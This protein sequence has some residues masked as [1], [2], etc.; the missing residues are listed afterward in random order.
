MV[1]GSDWLLPSRESVLQKELQLLHHRC[2]QSIHLCLWPGQ[3]ETVA[4]SLLL[5]ELQ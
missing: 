2:A 4:S 5:T 3:I 1:L